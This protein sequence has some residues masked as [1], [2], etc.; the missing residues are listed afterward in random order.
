[1]PGLS[2][3]V[4][5]PERG[6]AYEIGELLVPGEFGFWEVEW[7]YLIEREATGVNIGD[8]A[9]CSELDEL[10]LVNLF[11]GIFEVG[12]DEGEE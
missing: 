1:M 10:R 11:L 12:E 7:D 9:E 6:V 2:S 8:F 3:L 4:E 5:E